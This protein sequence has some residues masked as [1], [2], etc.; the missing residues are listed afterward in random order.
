MAAKL[1]LDS[2]DKKILDCLQDDADMALAEVAR[3]VGLSTTPCW[4]RINRLQEAGII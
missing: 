1:S 3:L 4:R 2:F